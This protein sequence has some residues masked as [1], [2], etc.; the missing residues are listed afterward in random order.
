RDGDFGDAL[1]LAGWWEAPLL[2]GFDYRIDEDGAPAHRRHIF[3]RAIGTDDG[4]NSNGA[5]D[6]GVLEDV[7][8]E[9]QN[10]FDGLGLLWLLRREDKRQEQG[11]QSSAEKSAA[12]AWMEM[13]SHDGSLWE[14]NAISTGESAAPTLVQIDWPMDGER[15]KVRRDSCGGLGI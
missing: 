11:E 3:D 4:A 6:A 2:Y 5:A 10:F 9:G 7:G 8:V 14:G 12:G 13:R 15:S 1:V